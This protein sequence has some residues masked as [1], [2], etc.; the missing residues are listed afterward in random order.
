M[1]H[2][3]ICSMHFGIN[4]ALSPVD[5]T[6]AIPGPEQQSRTE[7]CALPGQVWAF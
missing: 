7:T 2:S 5:V 3:L 4:Y 1:T 6:A